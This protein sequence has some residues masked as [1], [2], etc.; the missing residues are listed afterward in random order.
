M[1]SQNTLFLTLGE[2]IILL[3][4]NKNEEGSNKW[5]YKTMFFFTIDE[6][7]F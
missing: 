7:K 3:P 5:G 4:S 2:R 1:T 6:G